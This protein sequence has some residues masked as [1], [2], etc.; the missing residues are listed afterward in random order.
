M[1]R[2]FVRGLSPYPGAWA[3]INSKT[4]KFFKVKSQPSNDKAFSIVTGE[5][6]TD[7]KSYLY[8]KTA[9]GFIAVEEFQPEGKKRMTIQEFF[10]GNKI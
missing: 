7:N 9:D 1:I 2:N 6:V 8:I 5:L 10:R 3:V 4:Y